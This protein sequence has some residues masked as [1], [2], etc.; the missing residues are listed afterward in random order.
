M[1]NL[2]K[3]SK[4]SPFENLRREMDRFMDDFT[5]STFFPEIGDTNV[6]LWA[7]VAD[8]VEDDKEY[9]ISVDLPG[10]PK[11][12]VKVNFENGRLAISG[13]RKREKKEENGGLIRREKYYGNFYR[14][15]LIPKNIR[16]E[17]IEAGYKDGILTVHLPKTEESKPKVIEIK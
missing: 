5:A 2:T 13:E 4:I 10:V 14:S 9:L 11:K 1:S 16:N 15:F 7:P 17:G 12:D 6:D 8:M 3:F